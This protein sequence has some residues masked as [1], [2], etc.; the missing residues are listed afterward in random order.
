[1]KH[2]IYTALIILFAA[3][4]VFA[5]PLGN[6]SVNQFSR[7]EVEKT[8]I[9]IK[10]VLDIAE[11]PTFQAKGEIDADKNGVFS[12]EELNAYVAKITPNYL[13]NL[14][15]NVN[16]QTLSLRAD[17]QKVSLKDG[18]GNLPTL[19]IEWN[20]IA[21]SQVAE[22]NIVK[23][24]NKNF[25]ERIGWN[26]IIVNKTGGIN[27]F[28]SSIFGNTLSD[29]LKNYPE[30]L[31]NA[32][33]SERNAEFSFTANSIPA[34]A[35]VLQNRD[36][37]ASVAVQKDRL[38]ELI[39]I[40]EITPT[41]VLFALL[42]AFGLGAMHALSPGHGKT[43]VGAYLV[44]SRGT[45]KH[46][47]FLGLTVTITHTVG[48]FALGLITLFASNYILPEKIMPFLTF[49]SGLMVFYIG[50][51]LFKDRLLS[52]FG[53]KDIHSH[54]TH[55]H[56]AHSHG[57]KVHS[58]LPPQEITW[59]N[60]LGL[61]ISGGLL[62]CPSA[63]VLMLSAISLNRTGYGILLTFVFSLG[64]AATLTSIGLIFL[65]VGKIFGD[66]KFGESKILKGLPALS[67]FVIACFGAVICYQSLS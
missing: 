23:F 40:P 58:H 21:D 59:K 16:N 12:D 2:I 52:I 10:Q 30:N 61:G 55:E 34:T 27:V 46:A 28:D 57:G 6:F 65:Y 43:V 60:L 45:I 11:I 51:N 5:H 14:S 32:P 41:V 22:T 20:F 18:A 26:E 44:G 25:A 31:L 7:L 48:V 33:L 62:P 8:G 67:A 56:G 15:L 66:S 17:A 49:I 38:A 13:S 42:L 50:V 63:L 35:K 1:M 4:S 29:E 24:E 53:T 3:F 39:A 64:L 47:M 9:Q 37:N 19:R 36:G 54:H